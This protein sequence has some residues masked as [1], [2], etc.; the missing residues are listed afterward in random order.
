[1]GLQMKFPFLGGSVN[2]SAAVAPFLERRNKRS[3]D[4]MLHPIKGI[5][6]ACL[7]C[8][9]LYMVVYAWETSFVRKVSMS[10]Y[11]TKPCSD[12]FD[13]FWSD[14][15]NTLFNLPNHRPLD[16]DNHSHSS[17]PEGARFYMCF[18]FVYSFRNLVA[19]VGNTFVLLF[20]AIVILYYK[21]SA[22]ISMVG[23]YVDGCLDMQSLQTRLTNDASWYRCLTICEFILA[24][25]SVW[26]SVWAYGKY[27][28]SIDVL[29]FI[30]GM[31]LYLGL[32]SLSQLQANRWL[33]AKVDQATTKD[34]K[35]ALGQQSDDTLTCM[36]RLDL[37]HPEIAASMLE[38]LFTL[39]LKDEGG[40]LPKALKDVF[41]KVVRN[42][43]IQSQVSAY[44]IFSHL[45]NIETDSEEETLGF[46][47][48]DCD[49]SQPHDLDELDAETEG[50]EPMRRQLIR[51]SAL[52]IQRA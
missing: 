42:Q 8:P 20:I 15:S 4:C 23:H 41:G 52:E 1:V 34:S 16:C 9:T 28:N 29:V 22:P 6:I 35:D 37:K 11:P 24:A 7:L 10:T 13:C 5:V 3:C 26:P 44:E 21:F 27:V 32:L 39:I 25:F 45:E 2:T 46:C 47:S 36:K 30:P 33:L 43:N 31:F 19:A 18:G 12:M 38:Q 49:F 14:T 51:R 50:D 48:C 40:M 17:P